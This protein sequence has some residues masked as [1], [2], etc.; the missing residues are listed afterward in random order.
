MSEALDIARAAI[1]TGD[2]PVGAIVINKDGV[3]IGNYEDAIKK[4]RV[5]RYA[6]QIK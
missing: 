3:V 4:K 1:A 2:V 6:F 5:V